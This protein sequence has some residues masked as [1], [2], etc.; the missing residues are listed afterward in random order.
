M[1]DINGPKVEAEIV[2]PRIPKCL[3]VVSC[4]S[5][6]LP[7]V[8]SELNTVHLNKFDCILAHALGSMGMKELSV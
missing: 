2:V 4:K 8:S 3:F 5:G 7:L 6:D 1:P